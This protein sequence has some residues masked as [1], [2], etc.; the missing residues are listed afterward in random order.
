MLLF[1][2]YSWFYIPSSVAG[3]L[4][5]FIT[6]TLNIWFFLAIDRSSHSVSD[7]LI[8][9]FPYCVS[10]WTVYGWIASNTSGKKSSI[11]Q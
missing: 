4:I 7:T 8:N 9:F 3:F 6:I 10:F 5:A 1:K 11:T 2:K